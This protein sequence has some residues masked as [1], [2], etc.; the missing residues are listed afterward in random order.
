MLANWCAFPSNILYAFESVICRSQILWNTVTRQPLGQ[1]LIVRFSRIMGLSQLSGVLN[2]NFLCFIFSGVKKLV[3]PN[4]LAFISRL[5]KLIL[6]WKESF[7][8]EIWGLYHGA[9]KSLTVPSMLIAGISITGN[10]FA[11]NVRGMQK[12]NLLEPLQG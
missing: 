1:S 2:I 5:W 12:Q 11:I 6:H 10:L 7:K 3:L 8:F 9:L 4:L